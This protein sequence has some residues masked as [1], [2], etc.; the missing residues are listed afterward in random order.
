MGLNKQTR[1]PCGFCFLEFITREVA[2]EARRVLNGWLIDDR[3]VR[4]DWDLGFR[5]GRQYGR[6][7]TGFQVRDEL[8]AEVPEGETESPQKP[9]PDRPLVRRNRGRYR[10]QERTEEEGSETKGDKGAPKPPLVSRPRKTYD[11]WSKQESKGDLKKEPEPDL[12]ANVGKS[13]EIAPTEWGVTETKVAPKQ[14]PDLW[15]AGA[16]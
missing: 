5:P 10:R 11:Q 12:W 1:T 15:A 2:E 6:G 3:P 9:D 16:V 7:K 8:R 14:E 13:E 4:A